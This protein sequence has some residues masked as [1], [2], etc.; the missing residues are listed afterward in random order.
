MRFKEYLNDKNVN[1]SFIG[2][3]IKKYA[4]K[5]GI[6]AYIFMLT[7]Q[8]EKEKATV[9]KSIS[10]YAAEL[11][12]DSEEYQTVLNSFDIIYDSLSDSK[13]KKT[14]KTLKN[15]FEDN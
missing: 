9:L 15:E 10:D 4:N 13:L 12:K 7:W 6:P 11:D 3:T 14:V 8:F 2:D 5:I 1:E